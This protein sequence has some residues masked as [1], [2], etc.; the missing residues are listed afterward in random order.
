M[1][2]W[3][4]I[5]WKHFRRRNEDCDLLLERYRGMK[6][7]ISFRENA[8]NID[9]AVIRSFRFDALTI[10]VHWN[11]STYYLL[12]RRIK[13]RLW[14]GRKKIRKNCH[15][16]YSTR[17]NNSVFCTLNQTCNHEHFCWYLSIWARAFKPIFM[18]IVVTS[19]ANI[20]YKYIY[21]SMQVA[22]G[23][24]DFMLIVTEHALIAQSGRTDMQTNRVPVCA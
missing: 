10:S 7:F 20:F 17:A 8:V 13:C 12:R 23:R 15:L 11:S 24:C 6:F 4:I 5:W 1:L 14:K 2:I 19:M 22:Q 21:E 18:L 16:K 3:I 9:L